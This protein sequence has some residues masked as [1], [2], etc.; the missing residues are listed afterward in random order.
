MEDHLC[1]QNTSHNTAFVLLIS[2][3]VVDVRPSNMVIT[4]LIC[5][6]LLRIF[7]KKKDMFQQL[8]ATTAIIITNTPSITKK[9]KKTR[10]TIPQVAV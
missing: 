5:S 9:K 4:S 3:A 8:A 6:P 2:A 1:S 7:L 10:A